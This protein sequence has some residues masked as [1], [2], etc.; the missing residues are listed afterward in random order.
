MNPR[1]PVHP[2]PNATPA[3][4]HPRRLLCALLWLTPVSAAGSE[5]NP[6]PVAVLATSA[7]TP[8]AASASAPGHAPEPAPSPRAPAPVPELAAI[9]PGFLVHGAGP[10]LQGR[11]VT[12]QRLLYLEGAAVLATLSSGV[13]LFTTGAARDVVGPTALIGVAGVGSFAVSLL[14][15]A[16]ATWA[17]PDGLGDPLEVLPLLE[18]SIGY[19]YV[20]DPQFDYRHFLNV[21]LSGRLAAW[22]LA[23]GVATGRDNDRGW[24]SAGYRLLG[25]RGRGARA[26]SDGSYLEPR[27]GYSVHEF[28]RDGF[29][30]QVFEVAL[31]GRLDTDRY[32][33]DV[34]GAFFAAE[35]GWAKQVFHHE[36][37]LSDP[38]T[39][40][41]LLLARV[42]F[43]LYLGNRGAER[44]GGEVQLYYDHRHDGFAGG[45]KVNGLGSGPAGHFGLLASY[46]WS[47]FLGVRLRAEA[48]SAYIWGLDWV[49]RQW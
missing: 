14:A 1:A 28:E 48:G 15:G 3:C 25:P 19:L 32:L 22:H 20:Y 24:V 34:H 35:A 43:G 41:S 13:V 4:A 45:L 11:D 12:A 49:A 10:W 18:S 33:P 39:W 5:L 17:P 37:P 46:Q 2:L 9:F 38:Y 47:R 40:T 23:A 6:P 29:S 31:E 27:L 44:A 26:T 36:L 30:S 21:E 16:Y 7:T 42:G 8:A